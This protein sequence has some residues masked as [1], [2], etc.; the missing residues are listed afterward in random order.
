MGDGMVQPDGAEQRRIRQEK[1]SGFAFGWGRSARMRDARHDDISCLAERHASS[2]SSS[3]STLQGPG[4]IRAAGAWSL[5]AYDG[6]ARRRRPVISLTPGLLGLP[7][8]ASSSRI[9]ASSSCRAARHKFPESENGYPSGSKRAIFGCLTS[10]RMPS[11][12]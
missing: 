10:N 7:R 8:R 1:V 6:F 2:C 11:R 5:S 4:S 12:D 3:E 9:R